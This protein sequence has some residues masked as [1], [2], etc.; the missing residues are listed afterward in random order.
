MDGGGGRRVSGRTTQSDTGQGVFAVPKIVGGTAE[1]ELAAFLVVGYGSD[2][3]FSFW[4]WR[5]ISVWV[6]RQDFTSLSAYGRMGTQ[7]FDPYLFR[8]LRM[9]GHPCARAWA[10]PVAQWSIM[11]NG[12]NVEQSLATATG[13]DFY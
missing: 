2:G 10:I 11:V 6:G 13:C 1:E 8:V 12:R 9:P 3:G 4:W 7:L 5:L